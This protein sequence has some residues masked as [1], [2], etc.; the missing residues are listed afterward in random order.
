MN[1][2]ST[3]QRPQ[4]W[5]AQAVTVSTT[6]SQSVTQANL[7]RLISR[8]NPVK[9]VVSNLESPLPPPVP[10]RFALTPE[11]QAGA[12]SFMQQLDVVVGGFES[13]GQLSPDRMMT[14]FLKLNLLDPNNSIET[15]NLL[16]EAMSTLRQKSIDE[17][18]AASE[19][20]QELKQEAENYASVAAI[21][22]G[23]TSV[24]SICGGFAASSWSWIG[25]SLVSFC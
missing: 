17:S 19:R 25:L 6:A 11:S 15:H 13:Q 7:D 14:E 20:A 3:P 5:P 16:S 24:L 12:T 1:I 9:H 23:I 22:S 21:I 18:L 4:S 10:P 2:I 8:A